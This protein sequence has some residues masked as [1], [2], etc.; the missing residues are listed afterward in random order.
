VSSALTGVVRITRSC[1][2]ISSL[3]MEERKNNRLVFSLL[4][5]SE[6]FSALAS[7]R[8]PSL[9]D[10]I[11]MHEPCKVEQEA[12]VTTKAERKACRCP[13]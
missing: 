3:F 9:V 13:F 2:V 7:C 5:N 8:A 10:F 6:G 12:L 11:Y 4:A 1:G